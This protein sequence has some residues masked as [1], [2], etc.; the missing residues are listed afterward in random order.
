MPRNWTSQELALKYAELEAE[1]AKL[2]KILAAE[3]NDGR[4]EVDD[5]G[6]EAWIEQALKGEE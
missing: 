3:I 2:R 4:A 6:V 1:N 5:I